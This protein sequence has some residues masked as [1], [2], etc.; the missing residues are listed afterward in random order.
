MSA[1]KAE[2]YDSY[3]ELLTDGEDEEQVPLTQTVGH[4]PNSL[5]QG[6]LK[7]YRTAQYSAK[8]LNSGSGSGSERRCWIES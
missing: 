4:Q 3:D 7:P 6:Y 2:D 1:V 5:I 8:D